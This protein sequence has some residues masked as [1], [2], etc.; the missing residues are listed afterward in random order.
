MSIED[1]APE[2]GSSLRQTKIVMPHPYV[3]NLGIHQM[4]P[5]FSFRVYDDG[6]VV[7]KGQPDSDQLDA[8]YLAFWAQYMQ[9]ALQFQVTEG[10]HQMQ[11]MEQDNG[12]LKLILSSVP[13]EDIGDYGV[14]T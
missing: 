2:K 13:D 1:V 10:A 12:S 4:G 11:C 7:L 14:D 8:Q 3:F 9:S 6:E 5:G